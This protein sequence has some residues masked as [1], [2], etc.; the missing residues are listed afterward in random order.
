MRFFITI[1]IVVLFFYGSLYGQSIRF[2]L[3]LK[4]ACNNSEIIDSSWYALS[5]S[6]GNTY[7]DSISHPYV[8]FLPHTG[9]YN[10]NLYSKL[11]LKLAPVEIEDSGL[12]TFTYSEPNLVLINSGTDAGSFYSTCGKRAQGYEQDFY[13][14]GNV[15]IRGTFTGGK[16]KDSLVTFYPQWQ[17]QKNI[18]ITERAFH[19]RI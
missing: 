12:T 11:D 18:K 19:S 3:H 8:I 7:S 2:Q 4:N 10:I 15:R 1:V 5:D 17:H 9:T 16:M 13:P 14:N 6:L